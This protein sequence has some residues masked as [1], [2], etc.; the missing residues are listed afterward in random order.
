MKAWTRVVGILIQK[1]LAV[2][3]GSLLIGI[4]I[5]YFVIP[6]HLL[7][8]GVIGLGL[9]G[10]YAFNLQPGLT[11][12]FLSFPLYLV[13]FFYNRKYFYNGVHGLLVSSF[14]ID[15]FRPLSYFSALPIFISSL[16]G[17]IVL[18][19]GIS[20]MLVNNISAGGSDL[21]ALILSKITSI[22]VGL[23]ILCFD[24]I[25]ILTGSLVIPETT[26]LYS[27]ILVGAVGLTAFV[28]TNL[29]KPIAKV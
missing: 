15:L 1:I 25:V 5:N 29:L 4:G 12:I 19:I 20:I 7:D 18:G 14:F 2:L 10:K 28:F 9:L 6:H 13:A 21:L 8:G 23:I 3:F 27:V 11:I 26:L 24:S 16:S 22:N 17:G